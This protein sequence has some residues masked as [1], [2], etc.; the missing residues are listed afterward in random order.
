[1]RNLFILI[2]STALLSA[3]GNDHIDAVKNMEF[4][5]DDTLTLGQ[6]LDTRPVCADTQWDSFEDEKGRTIVEYSCEI[7]GS[8]E[9]FAGVYE[10][11][12][13]A[14]EDKLNAEVEAF[15][16]EKTRLSD[17]LAAGESKLEETQEKLAS[18]N[19]MLESGTLSAT[20]AT[21]LNELKML[22]NDLNHVTTDASISLDVDFTEDSRRMLV[23]S[24]STRQMADKADIEQFNAETVYEIYQWVITKSG[25]Q[26]RSGG[27]SYIYDKG[28]PK[29]VS[30]RNAKAMQSIIDQD[31]IKNMDDY[32]DAQQ[33]VNRIANLF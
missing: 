27:L 32:F 10:H 7:E 8:G 30:F 4:F 23:N 6:A 3:C 25:A 11:K 20:E 12:V 16:A 2:T 17:I 24:I 15:D 28:Q 26:L 33:K 14:L 1:M 18:L 13:Q 31:N 21:E 5:H 9:F 29:L 19:K 22:I